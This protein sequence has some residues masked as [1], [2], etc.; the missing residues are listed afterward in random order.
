MLAAEY[1]RIHN[2]ASDAYKV[3][4]KAVGARLWPMDH[5]HRLGTSN[6]QY[7]EEHGYLPKL[8]PRPLT[9]L[10]SYPDVTPKQRKWLNAQVDNI[11]SKYQSE[12]D[13]VRKAKAKDSASLLSAFVAAL[14]AWYEAHQAQEQVERNQAS[15]YNLLNYRPKPKAL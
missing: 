8:L 3:A 10:N 11:H 7:M 13:L 12:W 2:A 15:G 14:L 5:A 4:F 1:V 9:V 6:V